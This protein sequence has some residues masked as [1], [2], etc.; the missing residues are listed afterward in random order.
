M[1]SEYLS[2][3]TTI[4]IDNNPNL[5]PSAEPPPMENKINPPIVG[6]ME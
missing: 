6:I 4:K 2:Q 1:E 3:T 5:I